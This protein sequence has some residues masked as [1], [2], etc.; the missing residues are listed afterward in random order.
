MQ[1]W[2]NPQIA[3]IDKIRVATKF[4]DKKMQAPKIGYT[5]KINTIYT[6]G[7]VQTPLAAG[8]LHW[9]AVKS[10]FFGLAKDDLWIGSNFSTIR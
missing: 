6:Q 1:I 9:K 8:T 5:I 4:F 7:Q 10:Q 3:P 2:N